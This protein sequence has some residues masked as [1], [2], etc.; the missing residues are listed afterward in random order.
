VLPRKGKKHRQTLKALTD[1]QPEFVS[2]VFGGANKTPFRAVRADGAA[3]GEDVMPE[4]TIKAQAIARV[5]FA[6]EKFADESAVKSWLTDGGYDP[7]TT[8]T[9]TEG[10]FMVDSQLDP[11]TVLNCIDLMDTQGIK[12]FT[13]PAAGD[14]TGTLE[15]TA[16]EVVHP[17]ALL[18]LTMGLYSSLRESVS[19]GEFDVGLK[20]DDFASAMKA[21]TGTLPAK[22]DETF[23][24]VIRAVAPEIEVEK[25]AVM[26]TEKQTPD[27]EA[28]T[29]EVVAA[30]EEVTEKEVATPGEHPMPT[31]S[32][33]KPADGKRKPIGQQDANDAGEGDG[34]LGDNDQND[35]DRAGLDD[36]PSGGKKKKKEDETAEEETVEKSDETDSG[37]VVEETVTPDPVAALTAL[38]TELTTT[39][40]SMQDNL[41]G[42]IGKVVERVAAVEE[43]RQTRKG[44]DVDETSTA[45]VTE[46]VSDEIADIRRRSMLGMRRPAA[47]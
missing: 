25:E 45:S 44:A 35:G 24:T 20:I 33:P 9:K 3:V 39:V 40:K 8:I 30:T 11:A 31:K 42:E 36:I 15:L 17:G 4:Q 43:T 2:L 21:F 19:K 12:I 28:V 18:D 32:K 38:V 26:T 29:A 6:A 23:E 16:K 41:S 7:A 22:D 5:E 13:I 37:E 47:K 46:T 1:P 10:G 27:E 34:A 14:V